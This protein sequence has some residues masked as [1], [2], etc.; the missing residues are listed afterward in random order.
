MEIHEATCSCGA[1]RAVAHGDP[2]RVSAC[3]CLACQRRTGSAFGVQARYHPDAV[4]VSGESRVWERASDDDGEVR[5]FRFCPICGAI[6]YYTYEGDDE[7]VVIPV[8]A[9]A[10]P[11]FTAPSRFVYSERRHPWVSLA[12]ENR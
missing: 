5:S 10:D 9:F 12:G 2:V 3:H 6:V 11:A 8:G 1:L 7:V 4:E